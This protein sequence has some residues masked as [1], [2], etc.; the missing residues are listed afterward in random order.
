MVHTPTDEE[1]RHIEPEQKETRSVNYLIFFLIRSFIFP[2]SPK[3]I[4]NDF[5]SSITTQHL[6]L[7]LLKSFPR[8]MFLIKHPIFLKATFNSFNFKH[9]TARKIPQANQQQ[10][11]TPKTSLQRLYASHGY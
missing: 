7:K 11:Q 9:L 3:F 10:K 6:E 1:S 4:L 5:S 8:A 2:F